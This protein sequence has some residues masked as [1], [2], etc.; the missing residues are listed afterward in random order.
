MFKP[1][2]KLATGRP[3]GSRNKRTLENQALI[4]KHNFD[5]LEFLILLAKGD[6]QAC[7][8]DSPTVSKWSPTGPIEEERIPT[9][10]RKDAARAA[11]PYISPQLKSIDIEANINATV[12]SPTIEKYLEGLLDE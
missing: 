9:A 3:K 4:E 1:G 6:W 2:N 10:M 7:G 11:L 8:Y 5:P 12:E